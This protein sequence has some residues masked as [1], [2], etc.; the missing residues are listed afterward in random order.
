MHQGHVTFPVQAAQAKTAVRGCLGNGP[1]FNS[2]ADQST[3]SSNN[4]I[5][6]SCPIFAL[7]EIHI[8]AQNGNLLRRFTRTPLK[9]LSK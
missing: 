8:K 9:S 3:P 5:V 2:L 7:D 4:V 6:S 1:C